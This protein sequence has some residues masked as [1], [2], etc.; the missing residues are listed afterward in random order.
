[1]DFKLEVVILAV[2]DIDRTKSFYENLGWKLDADYASDDDSFRVVQFTPPGSSCSIAFGRGVIVETGPVGG[3]ELVVDDIERAHAEVAQRGINIS[4]I[5]HDRND[6]RR[7]ARVNHI[8]S[9]DP[10]R[11]SYLSYADFTDPDGNQWIVQ[12]VTTRFPER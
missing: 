8:A 5:Y 2:S 1:V 11:R 9:V 7:A 3:L 12:E 4:P 6:I 10:Q